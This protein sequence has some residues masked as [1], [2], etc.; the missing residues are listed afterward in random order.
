MH[1]HMHM[2]DMCM[3][4]CMCMCMCVVAFDCVARGAWRTDVY[5][6][7]VWCTREFFRNSFE[8]RLSFTPNTV[9]KMTTRVRETP[10]RPHL[11]EQRTS[12]RPRA[13]RRTRS[14]R[15]R[16]SDADLDPRCPTTHSSRSS[17]PS[18]AA[19]VTKT[20][21]CP[22]L[23]FDAVKGLACVSKALICGLS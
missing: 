18:T 19:P 10:H 21:H 8:F 15:G 14:Q 16:R 4:M 5:F 6:D 23:E 17:R 2:Y 22:L 7:S 11:T 9:T 13:M 12:K 1:M 3:H 20:R